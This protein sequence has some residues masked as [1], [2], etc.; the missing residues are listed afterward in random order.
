MAVNQLKAGAILNYVILCLNALVGIAYTPYMLRMLGQNEYGLYSLAA[1]LIA[2]LS[3]LDLGFGNAVIR[4]TA[5]FRAEGK[6]NEQ[7]S[8]FG[9]FTVLYSVIGIMALGVGLLLYFNVSNIFGKTLT[10]VEI[11]ESRTIILLMV[12]NLAVT[13]PLSIYGAIITAYEDFIFLRIVQ[14][15]RI[16][17]NTI[18]MIY[19]LSIGYKAIAMVVVVTICNIIVLLLNVFYCKYRIKIKIVF[20]KINRSFLKE[21]AIYSFWIFLN[22]IMDRIYWNTGQFVLGALVGTLAVAVF[23]VAIQLQGMYMMFSTA[24][25]GVFLPKV[26]AMVAKSNNEKEISDLFLRTGRIQYTILAFI[27]SGFVVFGRQFISFW[28]GESYADAYYIALLFFVP[29]TVPLI[30][31]IGITILQARNQMKFRSMIYIIIAL[32]SFVLQIPLTKYFGGIG[33]ASAISGAL[34]VGQILIMNI[35]Y[36]RKQ[37]IDIKRFWI[38]ISKMS[39]IP[40]IICSVSIII[41][42]FFPIETLS[43]FVIGIM[44]FSVVYIPLFCKFGMNRNER[45]LMLS[46]LMKLFKGNDFYHR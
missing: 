21:V 37:G 42:R 11:E 27:L 31:N 15:F 43:Q 45:K 38:E 33:C 18:V 44:I 6:M 16:C 7:Y 28:A 25:S 46:P 3:M 40:I 26:M 12:L 41:L 35:Y 10:A 24:I 9:M 34:I 36:Q 4:Y 8:M 39:M 1:S 20:G 29:L 30:Q 14:I 13:F 19:L 5:K 32:G 2:Y 22:V 17:I 23:S